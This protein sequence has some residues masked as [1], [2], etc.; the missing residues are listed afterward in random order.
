MGVYF[1]NNQSKNM[2][3]TVC[4]LDINMSNNCAYL[5]IKCS[6]CN[7]RIKGYYHSNCL[8]S[9]IDKLQ[10]NFVC[11]HCISNNHNSNL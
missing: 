7:K 5:E 4:S 2:K 1:S 11:T 9:H 3:C 10:S 8:S 6:D